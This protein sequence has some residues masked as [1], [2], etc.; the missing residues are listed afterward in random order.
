MMVQVRRMHSLGATTDQDLTG[1]VEASRE[2]ELLV[3][4]L[5]RPLE[6]RMQDGRAWR[7]TALQHIDRGEHIT[8]VH[9]RRTVYQV[10]EVRERRRSGA[11]RP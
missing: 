4:E 5:G 8:E 2:G 1:P 9:T 3:M 7:T 6:L 10:R 11:P